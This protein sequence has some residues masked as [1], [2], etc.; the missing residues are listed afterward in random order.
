MTAPM[1]NG[2]V[3]LTFLLWALSGVRGGFR[4]TRTHLALTGL[5]VKFPSEP[6]VALSEARLRLL[7]SLYPLLQLTFKT[8]FCFIIRDVAGLM[9]LGTDKWFGLQAGA[10]ENKTV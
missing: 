1:A 2:P 4:H 7:H 6:Q 9:V 5:R 10:E 8:S 3:R